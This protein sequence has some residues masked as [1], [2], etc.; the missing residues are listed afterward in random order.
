MCCIKF[1]LSLNIVVTIKRYMLR[2]NV[3][4]RREFNGK[5]YFWSKTK[6]H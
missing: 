5:L 4:G 3:T 1:R 2:S 6:R